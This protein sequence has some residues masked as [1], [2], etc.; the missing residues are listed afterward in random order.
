MLSVGIMIY[1]FEIFDSISILAHSN[2]TFSYAEIQKLCRNPEGTKCLRSEG[3]KCLTGRYEVSQG[4]VRSVQGTKCPK[5]LRTFKRYEVSRVRSGKGTKCPDTIQALE[6]NPH[7]DI[8]R[9]EDVLKYFFFDF[10]CTQD[11]GLHEP[12]LCVAQNG[13]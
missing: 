5:T 13:L 12:N 4:K 11:G 2:V 1:L 6:Q 3:T 10:E 9:E 8:L 7:L